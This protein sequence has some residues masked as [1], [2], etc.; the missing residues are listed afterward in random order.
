MCARKMMLVDP[1]NL[2]HKINP[3]SITNNALESSISNLDQEMNDILS[4]NTLND[5]IKALAYQQVLQKYILQSEK[6]RNKPLGRVDIAS[7]DDTTISKVND[8]QVKD[9]N[10]DFESRILKSVPKHL[11]SKASLLL[12]Y[13]KA[14][15]RISWDE[16]DQLITDSQTLNGTNAVDLVNDLLRVRKSVKPPQGWETLASVLKHSNIP[17]EVI[18]NVDRWSWIEKDNAKR[19]TTRRKH[20]Y[21]PKTQ[22]LQWETLS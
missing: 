16:K 8:I 7:L 14:N 6:Y 15:P 1:V 5:R 18:G 20:Q 13:F 3:G 17:K 22:K 19:F 10:L 2:R 9:E 4:D 21:S 12:E 11:K